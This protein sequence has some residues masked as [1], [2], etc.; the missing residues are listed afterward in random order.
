MASWSASDRKQTLNGC[1]AH[2]STNRHGEI[3]RILFNGIALCFPN[4]GSGMDYLHIHGF[5]MLD[6]LQSL[7]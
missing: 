3:T 5:G 6:A 7:S 2:Y 4:A 1:N